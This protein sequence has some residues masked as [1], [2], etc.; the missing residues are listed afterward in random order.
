MASRNGEQESLKKK[1]AKVREVV[2]T[3]STNDI[4]LALHSFD[5]DVEKTIRALCEQDVTTVIGDWETTGNAPVKKN[6]KQRRLELNSQKSQGNSGKTPTIS[7]TTNSTINNSTTV[8]PSPTPSKVPVTTTSKVSGQQKVTLPP[9]GPK[10]QSMTTTTTTSS[11]AT[12]NTNQVKNKQSQGKDSPIPTSASDIENIFKQI[13]QA[14]SEREKYLLTQVKSHPTQ[15]FNIDPSIVLSTINNLGQL[16]SINNKNTIISSPSSSRPNSNNSLK[17]ATSHSSLVSSVG[18]DSGL[19]QV[20]PVS[21]KG[22]KQ[23]STTGV[24]TVAINEGGINMESDSFSVDQLAEIQRKLQE[25][26]SAQGIDISLVQSMSENTPSFVNRSKQNQHDRQRLQKMEN[27][28]SRQHV[29][30]NK[31]GKG[32]QA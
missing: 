2:S 23:S 32:I 28:N 11:T 19:G 14:L 1:V 10:L 13:R 7:S 8:V 3:V 29:G 6:R 16:S 26:L 25:T 30:K 12:I 9:P 4:V 15:Y 27:S 17:N 5:L 22:K 18:D 24:S 20:S 31:L 21:V